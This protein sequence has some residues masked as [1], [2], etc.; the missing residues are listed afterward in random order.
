LQVRTAL[1]AVDLMLHRSGCPHFTRS[2]LHWTKDYIKFCAPDQAS[3]EEWASTL[4]DVKHCRTCFRKPA[5]G[6]NRAAT[7]G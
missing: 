4:G 2:P 7:R 6:S 1:G 3:L 5:T